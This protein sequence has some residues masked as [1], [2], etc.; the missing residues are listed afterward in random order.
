MGLTTTATPLTKIAL[1]APPVFNTTAE[2]SAA[3]SNLPSLES[4]KGSLALEHNQLAEGL[5][6]GL[7][8]HRP[9]RQV[10]VANVP[11]LLVHH[12]RP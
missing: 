5:S 3:K 11:S 7:Q 4:V 12:P 1:V 8:A 2:A 9:L 10:A 6:P